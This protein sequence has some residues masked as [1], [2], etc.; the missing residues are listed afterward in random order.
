MIY[1]IQRE[2]LRKSLPT[3]ID[4]SYGI[5]SYDS[6]NIYP[7]RVDEVRESSYTAKSAVARLAEFIDGEGFQ[8]PT[9]ANIVFNSEGMTGNDILDFIAQDKSPFT[10]FALHF[11]YNPFT[12][13][14]MEVTPVE[15]MY[16]R[17]GLPDSNGNVMEIAYSRNWEMDWRKTVDTV[18]EIDYYPVFDPKPE[19]VKGQIEKY[20]VHNYP[21]QIL[22]WTPKPGVYPK[23]RFHSVLD[24]AQSQSELGVYKLS[25][26]Q[27]KW[28]TETIIGYPGK[29]EDEEK[30]RKLLEK[31]SAHKGP[32]GSGILIIEN[33]TGNNLDIHKNLEIQN[34][35]KLFEFTT[36]DVKN[37]IR[38]ALALPAEVMGT[39]PESG[40]FNK[41]QIQDAYTYVNAMTRNDR[42]HIS[43]TFQKFMPYWKDQVALTTYDIIPQK[44]F[45]GAMAPTPAAPGTPGAAPAQA[46]SRPELNE[47]MSKLSGTQDAQ[48]QRIIR[49]YDSGKLTYDRA[50]TKIK[51]TFPLTEDEAKSLLGEE[52]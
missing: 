25:N 22:Y 35:D 45:D 34:T 46:V 21:G 19:V 18:L 27:N 23:C 51:L 49:Q 37:S 24:D 32:R 8:D 31:L 47:A 12:F 30:E 5:Q 28:T 10:G 50:L 48:L 40:M 26:I 41:T 43:R 13:R 3:V 7:Q 42:N 11:K 4:R 38:E 36:K 52:L 1:S 2:P 15:F 6:D 39:M 29:I 33:E 16:C 14:I 44:Y 17:L 9:L 20:G